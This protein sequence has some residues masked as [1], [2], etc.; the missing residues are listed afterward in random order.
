MWTQGKSSIH[1]QVETQL[2]GKGSKS[3]GLLVPGDESKNLDWGSQIP[4]P[5]EMDSIQK[6]KDL[7][8][9]STWEIWAE[10][11]ISRDM[12]KWEN[13]IKKYI[14]KSYEPYKASSEIRKEGKVMCKIS[15]MV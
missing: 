10:E 6:K 4:I 12:Q 1:N 3:L 2:N 7:R 15:F 13:G 9:L 5:S 8:R 14:K 11:Q